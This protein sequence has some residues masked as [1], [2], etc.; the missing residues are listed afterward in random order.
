MLSNIEPIGV[1]SNLFYV[2]NLS[3]KIEQNL[4]DIK[5]KYFSFYN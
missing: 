1:V 5:K 3:V 2:S 4:L